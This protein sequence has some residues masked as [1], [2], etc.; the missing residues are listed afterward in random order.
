MGLEERRRPQFKQPMQDLEHNSAINLREHVA[1][2]IQETLKNN[3]VGINAD[4]VIKDLFSTMRSPITGYRKMIWTTTV[5]DDGHWNPDPA[6]AR[7]LRV[8]N[9]F[10]NANPGIPIRV[11]V[12]DIP[13]THYGHVEKPRQLAGGLVAALRWLAAP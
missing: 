5:L 12:F 4:E 13:M 3:N 11:L 7:E 10:R 1:S 2:Q 8:A 6:Q 9:E